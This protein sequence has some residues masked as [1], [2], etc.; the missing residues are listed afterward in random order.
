MV[1]VVVAIIMMMVF[2]VLGTGD[3]DGAENHVPVVDSIA[4]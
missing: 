4:P 3:E 2:Y 1:A